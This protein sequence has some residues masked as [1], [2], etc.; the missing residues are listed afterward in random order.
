MTSLDTALGPSIC[1]ASFDEYPA[2]DRLLHSATD[3][4]ERTLEESRQLIA[5]C[6]ELIERCQAGDR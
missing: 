4:T 3:K 5:K 1:L 6:Q 2:M